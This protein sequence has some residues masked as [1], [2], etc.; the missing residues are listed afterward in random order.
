MWLNLPLAGAAVV[1]VRWLSLRVEERVRADSGAE[2]RRRRGRGGGRQPLPAPL[3]PSGKPDTWWRQ[4]VGSPVVERAWETLCGSIVQEARPQRPRPRARARARRYRHRGRAAAGTSRAACSAWPGA[5]GWRPRARP[6]GRRTGGA[7]GRAPSPSAP[8][9]S[10]PG[11][12]RAVCV[13]RVVRAADARP[14]LPARAAPADEHRVRRPRR[15]RAPL[16]Q[17]A[18]DAARV[19]PRARPPGAGAAAPHRLKAGRP[20]AQAERDAHGAGRG[21]ALGGPGGA[22]PNPNPGRGA[23]R[24]RVGT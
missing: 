10:A 22:G 20:P 23:G 3:A 16:R 14:R 2:Q 12:A 18:P 4:Q 21:R 7:G 1:G 8:R 19:R 13:R 5:R 6:A 17:P 9:P 11:A 24:A 15:A